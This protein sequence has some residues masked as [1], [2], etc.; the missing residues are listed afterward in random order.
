MIGTMSHA[1]LSFVSEAMILTSSEL[2]LFAIAV[3]GYF[4]M[5]SFSSMRATDT[6]NAKVCNENMVVTES[7]CTSKE[8]QRRFE[9]GDY[10]GV[11]A[12]WPAVMCSDCVP[13]GA[14]FAQ[15]I[16]SM[17]QLG[18][19]M[20]TIAG[21]VHRALKH[22]SGLCGDAEGLCHLVEDLRHRGCACLLDALLSVFEELESDLG[23]QVLEVTARATVGSYLSH[24]NT[25]AAASI[26]DRYN[27]LRS[28][29]PVSAGCVPQEL[30]SLTGQR[31]QGLQCQ[32]SIAEQ[33]IVLQKAAQNSNCVAAQLL[34][35][36]T[37]DLAASVFAFTEL[38]D[39]LNCAGLVCRGLH[40][41][42]WR[43]PDFWVA[44]GGTV[45][46]DSLR[47]TERPTTI[48]PMLGS[49]RRWVFGLDG[50]WSL[51][52][53]QLGSFGHPAD[54][55]RSVLGYVQV[56]QK[57]DA[58]L[59]DIWRLV[60]AA[61][62]AMQRADVQDDV[63]LGVASEL[64]SIA[65]KRSDIFGAVDNKDLSAAL[66]A[67]EQRAE[68]GKNADERNRWFFSDEADSNEQGAWAASDADHSLLSLSFLAV[69]DDHENLH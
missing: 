39:V 8:I 37:T 22:N 4:V 5:S 13:T 3:V 32:E 53:E 69:M 16:E 48:V 45:F 1:L 63:L 30:P 15:I 26:I 61:E 27:S 51:Q 36:L 29:M 35:G 57:G 17:Q 33:A 12:L 66:M 43:Q 28:L 49:F 59:S 10:R 62:S 31:G 11:L 60:R 19:H 54:A 55:L 47:G 2:I 34:G 52:V 18:I 20:Q 24:G 9:R 58:E 67:M 23:R 25:E 64:V 44:L 40:S 50:D 65:D 6:K 46:A 42:I 21:D 68:Q 38:S 56:L 41:A 14:A 7:E